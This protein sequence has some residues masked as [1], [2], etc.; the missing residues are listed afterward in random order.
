M[1]R[2]KSRPTVP[3]HGGAPVS[4]N[5]ASSTRPDAELTAR[6]QSEP[7]FV[8]GTASNQALSGFLSN[9]HSADEQERN[10][11][12]SSEVVPPSDQLDGSNIPDDEV[13][14]DNMDEE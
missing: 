12:P 9:N 6:E 7:L 8:P 14:G 1:G 11:I 13:E 4:R 5:R 10:D 2:T 3:H